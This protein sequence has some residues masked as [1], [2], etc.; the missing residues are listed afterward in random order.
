MTKGLRTVHFLLNQFD[1]NTIV[2]QDIE[3]VVGDAPSTNQQKF[4]DAFW[5]DVTVEK[6]HINTFTSD[7]NL[8]PNLHGSIP[9]WNDELTLTVNRT[10]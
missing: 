8:I 1:L 10:N 2:F 6:R 3:Q 5:L 9:I 7:I 4:F